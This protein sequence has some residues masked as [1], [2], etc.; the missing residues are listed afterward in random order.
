MIRISEW[1]WKHRLLL[2]V[3]ATCVFY[4]DLFVLLSHPLWSVNT[5]IIF[6]NGTTLPVWVGGFLWYLKT[7]FKDIYEKGEDVM[8]CDIKKLKKDLR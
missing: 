2:V 5:Q 7:G 4:F 6:L 3:Y 1:L 8:D